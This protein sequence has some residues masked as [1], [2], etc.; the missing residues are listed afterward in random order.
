MIKARALNKDDSYTVKVQEMDILLFERPWSNK[1]WKTALSDQNYKVFILL[2]DDKLIGFS[3]FFI[4][5]QDQQAHLLKIYISPEYRSKNYSKLL[6][7]PDLPLKSIYLEVDSKNLRARSFYEKNGLIILG[8][9]KKFYSDGSDA[10]KM[11]KYF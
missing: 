10:I 6:L 11:I 5:D 9:V 2:D 4:P 3:V 1:T 7:F 8:E